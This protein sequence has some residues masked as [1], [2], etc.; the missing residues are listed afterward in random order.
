MLVNVKIWGN[1]LKCDICFNNKWY[2]NTLKT[3]FESQ[4]NAL[5]YEEEARYMFE[6]SQCG[7]C[8]IFG[9]ISKE[10]DID[11]VNLTFHSI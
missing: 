2:K 8:K 1:E 5:I 9:M 7:N 4:E 6:C 10:N 11:N 3:E